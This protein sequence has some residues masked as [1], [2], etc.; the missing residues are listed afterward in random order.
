M[1]V[2]SMPESAADSTHGG[3]A[4]GGAGPARLFRPSAAALNWVI[5]IGLV[6]LSY[7]LYLRYLVI[8][9]VG[10]GLAC[11]GGLKTWLCLSRRMVT[12]L[13]ENQVFGWVGFGAAVLALVRPSLPLFTIGLAAS[14][15]GIVLHN[16]ALAG[17][18]A[19][20]LIMCFA[21]P[22]VATE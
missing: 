5:A 19:G 14:A 7:A 2:A 3:T 16:A 11:D 12:A 20:L 10:V 17:L 8:E 21:R 13:F 9:N 6:A 1:M 22:V 4:S 15:L 18:A